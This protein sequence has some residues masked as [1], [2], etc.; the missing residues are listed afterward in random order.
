MNARREVAHRRVGHLGTVFRRKT[1]NP[2]P[3]IRMNAQNQKPKNEVTTP[4]LG[5]GFGVSFG[6]LVSGFGFIEANNG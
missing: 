1:R 6:F 3:E 5:F 4:G 2:K